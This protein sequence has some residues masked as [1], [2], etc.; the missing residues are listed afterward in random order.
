MN[1]IEKSQKNHSKCEKI[2]ETILNYI[3]NK[4]YEM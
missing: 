4:F 2:V 1:E 3:F